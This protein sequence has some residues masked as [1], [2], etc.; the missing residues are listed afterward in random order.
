MLEFLQ[1]LR[2]CFP[3]L[4]YLVTLL[5]KRCVNGYVREVPYHIYLYR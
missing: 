2:N 1:I 4:V 3:Q 5:S